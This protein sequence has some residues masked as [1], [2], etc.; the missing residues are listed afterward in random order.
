MVGAA[1]EP[2]ERAELRTW[3]MKEVEPL[4]TPLAVDPGKSAQVQH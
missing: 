3:F 1:I 4:L 2:Q